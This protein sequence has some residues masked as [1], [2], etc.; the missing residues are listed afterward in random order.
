[1]QDIEALK[2]KQ[3]EQLE[4]AIAENAICEALPLR[5][6]RVSFASKLCPWVAYEANSIVDALEIFKLYTPVPWVIANDGGCTVVDTWEHI[7]ATYNSKPKRTPYVARE[8]LDDGAPYFDCSAGQGF[9]TNELEF[10]TEFAG[11][12]FKISIRLKYSPVR[13]SIVEADGHR[14]R[15]TERYRKVYSPPKNAKVIKWGYGPD[16]CK[17]TYYFRSLDDFWESM[18]DLCTPAAR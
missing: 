12:Q 2:K 1:M 15:G 4:E 14:Y 10:F 9:E 11:R 3:A 7:E 17:A 6:L 16:S 13:C 18:L 5:P 8:S